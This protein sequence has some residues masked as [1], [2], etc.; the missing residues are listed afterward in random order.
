MAYFSKITKSNAY[1]ITWCC[2]CLA[3]YFQGILP[4]LISCKSDLCRHNFTRYIDLKISID[5]ADLLEA[6]KFIVH[7]ITRYCFCPTAYFQGILAQLPSCKSDLHRHNVTRYIDLKISINTADLSE[8]TKLIVY[9][10]IRYCFCLTE[11]FHA[12]FAPHIP[13]LCDQSPSCLRCLVM[14]THC[15][16]P[17]PNHKTD[18]LL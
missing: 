9:C 16:L 12:I 15:G 14:L 10:I 11:Y 17:F 7:C 5:M 3:A 18:C 13:Y 1:Y 8:A 6:T 4:Q 2:F